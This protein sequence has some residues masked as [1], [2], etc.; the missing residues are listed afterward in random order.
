MIPQNANPNIRKC[1]SNKHEAQKTLIWAYERLNLTFKW[2]Y[3]S[4]K[5][6]IKHKQV[7]IQRSSKHMVPKNADLNIWTY[8]SN[9]QKKQSG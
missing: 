3:D 9:V 6:W 2:A 7:Q 4:T 8:K 5:C 1:K